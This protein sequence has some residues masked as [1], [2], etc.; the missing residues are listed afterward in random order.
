MDERERRQLFRDQVILAPMTKGSNLPFRRLCVEMGVRFSVGEMALSR[1][2]AKGRSGEL[3]LL[4]RH[5]DEL[6][7]GS[8]LCG[9]NP[10][11][12]A[13]QLK[14]RRPAA[15]VME[16]VRARDRD[17]VAAKGEPG[18]ND[19]CPCGSGKKYKRCCAIAV[20]ASV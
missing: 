9:R 6:V 13:D 18:R 10:E 3:A 4:R 14:R 7:F 11:V 2:V 20:G 5:A 8:Q 19:P 17:K 15:N 16:W 1:Y 12:M